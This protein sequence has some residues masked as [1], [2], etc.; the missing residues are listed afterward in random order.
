VKQIDD[1]QPF[2]GFRRAILENFDTFIIEIDLQIISYAIGAINVRQVSNLTHVYTRIDL[3]IIQ[4]MYINQIVQGINSNYFRRFH[5]RFI[6]FR[7]K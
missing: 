2:I 5:C 4:K 7:I 1:N 3:Q 6:I